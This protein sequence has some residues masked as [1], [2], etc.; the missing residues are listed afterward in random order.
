MA[1]T[2]R[3]SRFFVRAPKLPFQSEQPGRF[4]ELQLS[5]AEAERLQA[6][7]GAATI[8]SG[9]VRE[10]LERTE[11]PDFLGSLQSA[12]R[13]E[14]E[15]Q[16]S[17]V[18]RSL[19]QLEEGVSRARRQAEDHFAAVESF[20]RTASV[21][22][23]NPSLS[24][25]AT[26][27]ERNGFRLV[28]S[29]MTEFTAEYAGRVDLVVLHPEYGECIIDVRTQSTPNGKFQFFVGMGMDLGARAAARLERTGSEPRIITT[30]S[31]R[32]SAGLFHAKIWTPTEQLR[33]TRAFVALK[34]LW[35]A[36]TGFGSVAGKASE[37]RNR[38]PAA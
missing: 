23:T 21:P 1:A 30:L 38:R 18:V 31:S 5:L 37:T 35:Y 32:D 26:W 12:R 19:Q 33:L 14:H 27:W 16:D 25:F 28:A 20:A 24:A 36:E 22:S 15:S 9:L 7:P 17:F 10:G 6:L 4:R 2:T 11:Q 13:R 29:R 3:K 34:M 8:L